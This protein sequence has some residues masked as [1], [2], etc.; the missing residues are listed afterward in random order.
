MPV[1]GLWDTY[2]SEFPVRQKLIYLNHAAV[3]PLPRRTADAMHALV[4]DAATYGSIHYETWMAAY[5]KLRIT[6]AKLINAK[7]SEIALV[8]NTSEGI[9]MVATGMDWKAPD[10]IVAFQ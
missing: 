8:K 3:S 10:I 9:A 2:A 6:T 1:V 5:E 7:K 4:T